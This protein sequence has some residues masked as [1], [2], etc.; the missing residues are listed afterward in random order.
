MYV[1]A[2]DVCSPL[3]LGADDCAYLQSGDM[4]QKFDEQL[5]RPNGAV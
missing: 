2:D 4:A 5:C 3:S 1:A